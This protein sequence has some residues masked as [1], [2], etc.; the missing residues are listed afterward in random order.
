MSSS[1]LTR[2]TT[3]ENTYFSC[4]SNVGNTD[5][6]TNYSKAFT[7]NTTGSHHHGG[8]RRTIGDEGD[9]G[10][11]CNFGGSHYHS[12][13]LEASIDQ[14]YTYLKMALW[15]SASTEIDAVPGII[16]LWEGVTPP[17]GWAICNGS[18]GTPDLRN[19]FVIISNSSTGGSTGGNNTISLR[20]Y[21]T[22]TAYHYHPRS[23]TDDGAS[24][25]CC[26][27]YQSEEVNEPHVSSGNDEFTRDWG[28]DSCYA[29]CK[30]SYLLKHLNNV[31]H[32]H[33]SGT[34]TKSHMPR[35]Y[36]LTFI[37][38]ISD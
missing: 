24:T 25:Y 13:K 28:G 17:E 14:R 20:T 34:I 8:V 33:N 5:G 9:D 4:G 31:G 23:R 26:S 2:V 7:T 11:W 10:D 1:G 36:A 19:K 38:K 30:S 29:W 15:K 37:M 6:V 35:Y 22:S 16:A 3:G 21:T 12:A 32:T 27:I 18:N